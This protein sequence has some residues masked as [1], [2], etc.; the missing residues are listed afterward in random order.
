MYRSHRVLDLVQTDVSG[1]AETESLGG[2]IY[3]TFIDD[4][5]RCTQVYCISSK[6]EVIDKIKEYVALTINKF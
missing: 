3:F 4:Y 1:P 2:K 6:N 5:S